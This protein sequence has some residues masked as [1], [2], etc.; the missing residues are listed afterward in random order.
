MCAAQERERA[1]GE[2]RA[3]LGAEKQHWEFRA[4]QS[5]ETIEALRQVRP[6]TSKLDPNMAERGDGWEVSTLD[7]TLE[8]TPKEC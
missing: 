6:Q 4:K 5:E 1:I 2:E 7:L 3:R 8:H